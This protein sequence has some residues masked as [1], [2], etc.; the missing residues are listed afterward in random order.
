MLALLLSGALYAQYPVKMRNLWTRP[1][2]HVLFNGYRV[3]FAIRDINK[4]LALLRSAGDD[5]HPSYCALDT[6]KDFSYELYEG[7]RTEYK[8]QMESLLQNVVGPFLITAGRAVV[9]DSRNRVLQEVITD[10]KYEGTG[11]QNVYV[12]FFDPKTK[13]MLFA[14]IMSLAIYKMDLGIDD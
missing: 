4:T 13:K 11:E 10:I 1:Q 6:S 9:Q 2:V 7:T 5:S 14:G 8:E 12:N 3:S